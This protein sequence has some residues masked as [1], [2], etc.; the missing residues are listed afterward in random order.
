MG[1]SERTNAVV[2]PRISTQWFVKMHTLATPALKH[3]LDETIQF[4]PAKFKNMYKAWLEEVR[5]WCISRQLWWGHRIPA[6]HLPDGSVVVAQDKA[7]ALKKAQDQIGNLALTEA[8][9]CQDN[10]V[11]DTWFSSWL[12]PLSVFDGIQHPDNPDFRYFYPTNDLVTAPEIIFFLG[13]QNDHGGLCFA[14]CSS[15]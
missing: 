2:E 4:H 8:D 9:L 6:Y 7:A 5:D 3:V 14:K 13:G 10:D 11:L 15:F 12:W 1:Y